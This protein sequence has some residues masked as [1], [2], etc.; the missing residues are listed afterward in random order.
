MMSDSP[1][2][3]TCL[4]T[5]IIKPQRCVKGDGKPQSRKVP[6]SIPLFLFVRK[7]AIKGYS[8][9]QSSVSCLWPPSP[10]CQRG[11][12][13]PGSKPFSPL[14]WTTKHPLLEDLQRAPASS[15]SAEKQG[16]VLALPLP[17]VCLGRSCIPYCL[18]Q[19]LTAGY[20]MLG[21]TKHMM[22]R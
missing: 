5:H 4:V 20:L 3:L 9:G 22:K 15:G 2:R 14:L 19:D 7:T 13:Q 6:N 12:E 11:G 18:K 16:L 1:L 17:L 8:G 10:M 21:C